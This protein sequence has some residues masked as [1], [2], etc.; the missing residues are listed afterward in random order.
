MQMKD[1]VFAASRDADSA[2]LSLMSRRN[3][4]ESAVFKRFTLHF[5]RIPFTD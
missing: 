5:Q 1:L 3:K 2:T 4:T